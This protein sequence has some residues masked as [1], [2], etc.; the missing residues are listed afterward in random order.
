M[1]SVTSRWAASLTL[2]SFTQEITYDNDRLLNTIQ[3][4]QNQRI[5]PIQ[6][7]DEEKGRE[8][9]VYGL[10]KRKIGQEDVIQALVYAVRFIWSGLQ[11]FLWY[12][13]VEE[14]IVMRV[15]D[16]CFLFFTAS[17]FW[18]VYMFLWSVC[19]CPA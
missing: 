10:I 7:A 2:D 15:I 16:L 17:L 8:L 5:D 3:I 11:S 4:F 12:M 18:R 6:P 9:L 13:G 19:Q 1:T 14:R